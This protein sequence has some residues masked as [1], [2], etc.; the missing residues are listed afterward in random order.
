MEPDN[1][2]APPVVAVIVVHEPGPWFDQTL[3]A[4][5]QQ[6]YPNLR[7]LF[8]TTQTDDALKARIRTV[9]PKAFVRSVD[10]N[11][12]FGPTANEVLRLVEGDNGFLL[13][14]HDDVAPEPDA[15]RILVEEMYRSMSSKTIATTF[16][17]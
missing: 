8:L 14:C 16:K 9:F 4:F 5:S 6:D 10:S 7:M 12:G 1:Q 13:I 11:P 15:I 3:H 17:K 2:Q